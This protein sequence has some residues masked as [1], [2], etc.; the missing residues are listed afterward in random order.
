MAPFGWHIT[1]ECCDPPQNPAACSK[2]HAAC[3]VAIQEKQ[4]G[5]LGELWSSMLQEA[6]VKQVDVAAAFSQL[7]AS[8]GP[9]D[10]TKA[11]KAAFLAASAMKNFAVPELESE[12][13]RTS[14]HLGFQN[15]SK[16]PLGFHACASGIFM[17]SF[18]CC[19]LSSLRWRSL[20]KEEWKQM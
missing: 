10:I 6:E 7:L 18:Q 15:L 11:K 17:Q 16:T 4:E 8:K 2:I 20:L 19:P 12:L 13:P 3:V 9:Q 1:Q 5:K 14:P